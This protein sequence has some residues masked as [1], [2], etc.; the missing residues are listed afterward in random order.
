[1]TSMILG[2]GIADYI[3]DTLQTEDD[4]PRWYMDGGYNFLHGIAYTA[5]P[6]GNRKYRYECKIVETGGARYYVRALGRAEPIT[7]S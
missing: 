5:F 6:T 3:F 2:G 7:S 4:D 1:M